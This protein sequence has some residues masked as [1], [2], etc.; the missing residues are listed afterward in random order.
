MDI[1]VMFLDCPEF[2]DNDDAT[3]CGLPSEVVR[4][5][6]TGSTDG[7]LE[8][9]VIQCPSRHNFNGPIQALTWDRTS[10]AQPIRLEQ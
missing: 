9:V 1:G 2:M 4:R 6:N 10:P 3:R 8:S 5:Y 7:S